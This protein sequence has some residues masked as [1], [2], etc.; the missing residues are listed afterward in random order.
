LRETSSERTTV[1]DV[2]LDKVKNPAIGLEFL[3]EEE[4]N[5]TPV[6][7]PNSN[8]WVDRAVA[9][10]KATTYEL[11][12]EDDSDSVEEGEEKP[13]TLR[14]LSYA[15][16]PKADQKRLIEPHQRMTAPNT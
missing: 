11:F 5:R 7:S 8:E 14:H 4:P 9:D 2:D 1:P 13:V 15:N 16:A 6:P 12:G 3:R 10:R